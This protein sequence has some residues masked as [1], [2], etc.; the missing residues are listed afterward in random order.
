MIKC[1]HFD[2]FVTAAGQIPQTISVPPAA[3]GLGKE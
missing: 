1:E 2:V 3:M